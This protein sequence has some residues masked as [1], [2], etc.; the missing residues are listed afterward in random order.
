V[1]S[2][3]VPPKNQSFKQSLKSQ[4]ATRLTRSQQA[5]F[6]L[7]RRQSQPRSAQQLYSILRAQQ[8]IGLATVYRALET[9]KLRGFIQCRAGTTGELFYSLVE[10]DQHYLTCLQCGQSFPLESCPL[11]EFALQLQPSVPF[12]IYYHTLEFFGLCEPCTQATH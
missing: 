11:Q 9:L 6:E 3:S 4:A 12:K 2:D 7:L 8:A 10:H 5:V 1:K